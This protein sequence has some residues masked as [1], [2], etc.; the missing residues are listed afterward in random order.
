MSVSH[1]YR[2]CHSRVE[3]EKQSI[4]KHVNVT[5]REEGMAR[6]MTNMTDKQM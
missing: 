3:L 6:A 5:K 1:F 2:F 4:D